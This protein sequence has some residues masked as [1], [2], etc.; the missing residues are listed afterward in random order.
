M[1]FLKQGSESELRI[2]NGTLFGPSGCEE[3]YSL[4]LLGV[5]I[6]STWFMFMKQEYSTAFF[7]KLII[8]CCK[9]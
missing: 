8:K 5:F 9:C 3:D 6:S 2:S 4:V 1:L 7:A